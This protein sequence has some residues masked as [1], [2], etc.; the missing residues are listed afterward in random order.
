M[1]RLIWAA[2]GLILHVLRLFLFDV[3][4]IFRGGCAIAIKKMVSVWEGMEYEVSL[5]SLIE[6]EGKGREEKRMKEFVFYL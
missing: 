1:E 4:L 2:T 3:D 5:A 6:L